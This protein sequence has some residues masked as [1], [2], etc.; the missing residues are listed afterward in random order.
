M[1]A[2]MNK[3]YTSFRKADCRI[4]MNFTN[5][6]VKHLHNFG[7]LLLIMFCIPSCQNCFQSARLLH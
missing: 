4:Y 3:F 5:Y 1:C 2:C 7:L 6:K